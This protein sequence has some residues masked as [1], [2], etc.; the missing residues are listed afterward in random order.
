MLDPAVATAIQEAVDAAFDRQIAF[1]QEL[2]RHPSMRGA[3]QTAQDFMAAAFRARGLAVDRWT[4][5]VDALRGLPGFAP[6]VDVSY[7]NALNVVGAYRPETPGGRSL[8]LNGHIDV[9]PT[10]AAERWTSGPFDPRVEG[11]W[12]YGRGAGDMKAGLAACLFAFDAVRAAGFRIAGT[13]YLQ[14]VVEEECT[15]NG[16]LACIERG[17]RADCAIVPE[18]L[19]PKLLRAQVGPIWFR[20]TIEGDPQ[21]AS[22]FQSSGANAIEKA[23][24]VWQR[25]KELESKWIARKTE[26]PHFADMANPVRLNLGKIRGGDWPSSVPSSCT[27]EGR[28]AIYPGWN[29]ADACQEIEAA[30]R[31][32]AL[33]DP[34]LSNHPPIVEYHGFM[35]EGMVL[36]GAEEPERVLADAHMTVFGETLQEHATPATTD[37]RFFGLYQGTPA[38]V[39][40]PVCERAHGFDERV[41][42]R[43]V[44]QVTKTIALFVAEWCGVEPARTEALSL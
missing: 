1:T 12:L 5:D 28:I 25:V 4:I 23:F 33:E 41:D 42:L 7:E 24:L 32:A 44:R 9:V 21:H 13:V 30:V 14:S 38:L 34:Y 26:H 36:T 43:S 19:E 39:Y 31:D 10:G 37:G 2:V 35:A 17:Y 40:G 15:G 22:G 11:D 8:I 3:E 18:P 16:A 6:V 27:I 29:P 20:I